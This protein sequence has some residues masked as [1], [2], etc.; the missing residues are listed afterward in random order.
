[1]N[2]IKLTKEQKDKLLEMCKVLF[3]EHPW[4]FG[5]FYTSEV[6]AIYEGLDYLDITHLNHKISCIVSRYQLDN[7]KIDTSNLKVIEKDKFPKYDKLEYGFVNNIEPLKKGFMISYETKEDGNYDY[8]KPIIKQ[9]SGSYEEKYVEGIHWFEFCMTHLATKIF[10]GLKLNLKIDISSYRG[11]IIQ[12]E[13]H[14]IDYLFEEF[15]KLKS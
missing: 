6:G 9:H 13:E 7:A 14:P 5:E 11:R 15:L 10:N 2:P 1:M 8:T 3:P 4:G 12:Y